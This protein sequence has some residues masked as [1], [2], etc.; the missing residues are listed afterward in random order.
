MEVGTEH[1]ALRRKAESS[2]PAAR[3]KLKELA[4]GTRRTMMSSGLPSG[5]A[6]MGCPDGGH[7]DTREKSLRT[8]VLT[9]N[10]PPPEL[11]TESNHRDQLEAIRQSCF[12]R[13]AG[14]MRHARGR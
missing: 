1:V 3:A 7:P 5:R 14:A 9:A 2:R 4:S 8:K 11:Q 6:P 12:I 13:C 10:E